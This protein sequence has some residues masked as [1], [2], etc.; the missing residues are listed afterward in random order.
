MDYIVNPQIGNIS[1]V[2]PSTIIRFIDDYNF[3]VVRE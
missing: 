3:E 1:D 2:K